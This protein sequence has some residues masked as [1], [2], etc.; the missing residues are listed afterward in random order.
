MSFI[1][2]SI[3]TSA[4]ESYEKKEVVIGKVNQYEFFKYIKPEKINI[5]KLKNFDNIIP[6]KYSKDE[7]KS[8]N[9]NKNRSFNIYKFVNNILKK[10][11]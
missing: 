11:Q 3:G 8:E 2:L 5:E 6:F 1:I 9:N 4:Y 10:V 7:I